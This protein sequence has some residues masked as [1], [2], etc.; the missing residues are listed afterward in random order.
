ME[1]R[2]GALCEKCNK[3]LNG[4][5]VHS[6]GGLERL[7]KFVYCKGCRTIYKVRLEAIFNFDVNK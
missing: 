6:S 5:Y 4:V 1:S 7:D 2:Q 3:S